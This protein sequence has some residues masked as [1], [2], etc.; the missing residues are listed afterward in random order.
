[1]LSSV[2]SRIFCQ[3]HTGFKIYI[4]LLTLSLYIT[5]IS[6]SVYT[7]MVLPIGSIP[8]RVLVL[9]FENKCLYSGIVFD[10]G[11]IRAN[12]VRFLWITE[13]L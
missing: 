1:M 12:N 7:K 3:P 13:F 2:I 10:K 9:F 5:S 8:W 6:A 11:I 4:V